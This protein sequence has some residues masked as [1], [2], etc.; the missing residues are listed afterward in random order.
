MANL[1][2]IFI[3]LFYA[4]SQNVNSMCIVSLGLRTRHTNNMIKASLFCYKP[5]FI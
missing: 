3:E 4:Y 2:A 1:L 5:M